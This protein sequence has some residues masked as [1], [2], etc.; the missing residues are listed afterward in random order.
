MPEQK[1]SDE[2]PRSEIEGEVSD[3]IRSLGYVAVP[4]VGESTLR[5]DIGVKTHENPD[6]FILGVILDGE[7][8]RSTATA[9]DRDRLREQVLERMG[10]N[11]HR[12]WSPE[13]V[14]RRDTEVERLAKAIKDAETGKKRTSSAHSQAKQKKRGLEQEKVIERKSNQLPGSEPYRKAVLIPAHTFNKIQADQRE[15][16]LDL[17]RLEVRNLLPK[18]V[19]IEGPIHIEFAFNRLNKA[20]NLKPI[21]PSFHKMYRRVVDELAIKSRF[22]KRGDYL[23]SNKGT[24]V[25]VRVPIDGP[26][27]EVRPIEYI[28]PEEIDATILHVL[29]HS[30]GLSKESLLLGTANI[31]K[32]RQTQK[33]SGILEVRLGK[34]I[35]SRIILQV[36]EKLLIPHEGET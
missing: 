1:H 31:F 27:G 26:D 4:Q 18:I 9:R 2:T 5:V 25:K 21:P 3:A 17:Y 13:W 19:S 32:V 22:E 11:L 24:D 28:P 10:W 29:N 33:T 35:E 8:Y 34:L 14:Q 23:W 36:G 15:L 30:M 20:V 6:R 7:S 12:V 16:Y